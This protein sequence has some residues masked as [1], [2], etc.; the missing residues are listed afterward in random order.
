M[1]KIR[2]KHRVFKNELLLTEQLS[3]LLYYGKGSTP[4]K[5]DSL[6]NRGNSDYV[7]QTLLAALY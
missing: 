1:S 7:F 5:K 6:Q 3:F 4:Q 2:F